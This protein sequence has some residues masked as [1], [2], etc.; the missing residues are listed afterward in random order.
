VVQWGLEEV[1]HNTP[2]RGRGSPGDTARKEFATSVIETLAAYGE[3]LTTGP[4]GNVASV[5]TFLLEAAGE[6][7]TKDVSY[8]VEEGMK[9]AKVRA[10]ARARRRGESLVSRRATPAR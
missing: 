4:K 5:L 7:A 6:G 8:L 3:R 9:T 2:R 10:E 1:L